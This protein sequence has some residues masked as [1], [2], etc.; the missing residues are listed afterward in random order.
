MGTRVPKGDPLCNSAIVDGFLVDG[1]PVDRLHCLWT[2]IV[3]GF[4]VDRFPVYG[5]LVGGS[6]CSR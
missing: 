2:T 3:D 5:I 1:F 6:H 4:P